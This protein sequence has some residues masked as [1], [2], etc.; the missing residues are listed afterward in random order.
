[1]ISLISEN[2]KNMC[3]REKTPKKIIMQKVK[4]FNPNSSPTPSP[5]K[6]VRRLCSDLYQVTEQEENTMTRSDIPKMSLLKPIRM[7]YEAR[8]TDTETQTN[9][10]YTIIDPAD[11]QTPTVIFVPRR[12][13]RFGP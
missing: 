13:K 9:T 2:K 1:M 12:P 10:L 8:E 4:L 3:Y 6:R 5:L 7:T 11:Y